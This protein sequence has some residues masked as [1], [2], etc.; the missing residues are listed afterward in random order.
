MIVPNYQNHRITA[1]D[2]L[3][4]C[5]A[6]FHPR[7]LVRQNAIDFLECYV[8]DIDLEIAHSLYTDHDDTLLKPI[9]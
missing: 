7:L 2:V 8:S 5:D 9:V 3:H 4:I 6:C 1:R